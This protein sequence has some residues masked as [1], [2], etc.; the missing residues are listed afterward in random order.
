[1]NQQHFAGSQMTTLLSALA[2]QPPAFG[3]PCLHCHTLVWNP[4]R[5]AGCHA[6]RLCLRSCL[7]A[8]LNRGSMRNAKTKALREVWRPEMLRW[9]VNWNSL[10]HPSIASFPLAI[11][12]FCYN[13]TVD[14]APHHGLVPS[15]SL[16]LTAMLAC[17]AF[18]SLTAM[19]ACRSFQY[20]LHTA[21]ARATRIR[22]SSEALG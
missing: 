12:I 17:S 8:R 22:S 1:M 18:I 7:C 2:Q 13:P 15:A 5:G 16:S 21:A 19:F 9:L 6:A 20:T 10:S 3:A 11:P 4:T 14:A